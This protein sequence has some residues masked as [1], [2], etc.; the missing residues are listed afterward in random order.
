M[1]RKV[2][3]IIVIMMITALALCGCGKESNESADTEADTSKETKETVEEA[4]PEVLE[5]IDEI[6]TEGMAEMPLQI[7][8][9]T[10][11]EDG[12]IEIIP[13]EDLK[14]NAEDNNEI[15]DGAM[16]PFDEFGKAEKIYLVKFGNGG[17]R[18]LIA[19]MEDGTLSALSAKELIEDHI[20]VVMP[21]VSGRDTFVSVEQVENE[22]SFGVIGV[23]D[24]GEEVELDFSL[25]F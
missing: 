4:A 10:L 1:K 20:V 14:K 24:D 25:N 15:K 7:E 18:T 16:W 11:Y 23:L 2:Y 5:T 3:G 13:T 8:K 19:L 21:N 22:D 12:R 6:D 9:I 17:Y